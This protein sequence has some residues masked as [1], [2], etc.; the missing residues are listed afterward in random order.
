MQVAYLNLRQINLV[1]KQQFSVL[2]KNN[3]EL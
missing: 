2:H 1:V 3:K